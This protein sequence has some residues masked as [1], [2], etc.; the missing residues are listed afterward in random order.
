MSAPILDFSYTYSFSYRY[1]HLHTLGPRVHF[2]LVDKVLSLSGCV[3]FYFG[4]LPAESFYELV[5]IGSL[6]IM[7]VVV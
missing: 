6:E 7:P 2:S 5:N 1:S 4:S 3:F